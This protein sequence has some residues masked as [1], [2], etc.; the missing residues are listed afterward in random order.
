MLSK[1]EMF[2]TFCIISDQLKFLKTEAKVASV[3]LYILHKYVRNL[4]G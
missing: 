1:T 3:F 2:A 4:I